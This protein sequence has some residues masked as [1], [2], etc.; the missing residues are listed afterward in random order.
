MAERVIVGIDLG[1]TNSLVGVIDTGFPVVIPDAGGRRLLPSIVAPVGGSIQVGEPARRQ[2]LLHPRHTVYSAKRFMGRPGSGVAGEE[3]ELGYP[4]EASPDG[5]ICFPIEGKAWRPEE[6]AAEVLKEL[7]HSAERYLGRAVDAAVITV[8]AYFNDA[9]RTATRRAGELAGFQVERILNE[10]TAAALAYGLDQKA[11]NLICAVYDLG[12]GTF[13]LSIL[14]LKEGLFQVLSTHGDT[15]L[16]GDDLDRALAG[17][18]GEEIKESCGLE[19]FSPNLQARLWEEVERAKC[20]LSEVETVEIELPFVTEDRHFRRSLGRKELE[21]LAL[22]ILEKT[23]ACCLKALEDAGLG[24]ADI[25]RV[26]LVGGQTRMPLVRRL[27]EGIFQR[28][29]DVSQ[30]PDQAVALGAA[31]QAGILSGHLRQVVLV[32]VTPLSLGIETFGGLMNVIIPRNSTIPVKA[33]EQFTNAADGQRLMKIHVLQGERELVQDNFSLGSFDLEFVPGPRGSCRVGV[34]FEID[35]DGILN[36]LARDL[37]SGS[38]KRVEFHSAVDVEDERVEKMVEESLEHAWDDLKARQ[39]VQARLSGQKVAEATR[40]ALRLLDER[41]PAE[42]K[43]RIGDALAALEERMAGEDAAA[44]KEAIRQLDEA[45]RGL[46]DLL[47][48]TAQEEVLRS[49]GVL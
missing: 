36:V 8:P 38:E 35:A 18:L 9:Q 20:R 42:E 25:D 21:E 47:V 17:R 37:K 14:E 34:Q 48:E 12:G 26:I 6:I 30:D 45:S 11:E 7:K 22:P 13:D 40:M 3:K 16:G 43:R 41:V 23:R 15:R 29:P 5:G 39:L 24:P 4:V 19:Q 2:R 49:K 27:V 31:I 28:P 44:L 10:P 33:G 46:A 32:D 1:T